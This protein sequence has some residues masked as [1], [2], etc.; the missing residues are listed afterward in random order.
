MTS[1]SVFSIAGKGLKFDTVA[2]IEA[3]IKPL[4]ES[5][6]VYTEIQL[7]GNTYGVPACEFLATALRKQTRLSVAKLDDMFTTRLVTE[8]PIALKALLTALLEVKT[9]QT[10]D[11]SDNAFGLN[12][13]APL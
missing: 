11:L 9:L 2:D 7:G 13:Q 6:D 10:I 8:I 4:V 3:Y 12:T 5:S 1:S